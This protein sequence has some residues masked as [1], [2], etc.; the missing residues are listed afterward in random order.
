MAN[1]VYEIDP[2]ADTVIILKNSSTAFAVWDTL[3]VQENTDALYPDRET[4]NTLPVYPTPLGSDIEESTVD[5]VE[6]LAAGESTFDTTEEPVMEEPAGHATSIVENT[7]EPD[8]SECSTNKKEIHYYVSSRHLTLASSRFDSML[9]KGKWTEGV[10][11]SNDGRYH[12]S[13][14]DWDVEALLLLLNV[15]H[16]RN[17]QVP[18][19]LSLEMLAKIAVL[20][21]YYDCAEAVELCIERWI[22]HIR[23]TSPVPS[24]FCRDLIL[25]MCIAWVL[26]MPNEFTQTT[27]IAV[28]QVE[29]EL[30]TL[31]LPITACVGKSGS[32]SAS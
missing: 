8:L 19:S 22:E 18:R 27:A 21:D 10:P 7:I 14:E 32:K 31:G 15:L 5:T 28:R 25:W 11:D 3:E 20:I 9:T 1:V 2:A 6:Q 26:R 16:H 29:R 24:G 17:R 12:I 4:V 23:K 30:L 13:A